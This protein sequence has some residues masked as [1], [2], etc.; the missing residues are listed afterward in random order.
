M[1]IQAKPRR[2]C[3]RLQFK[4]VQQNVWYL[5]N[6]PDVTFIC[7]ANAMMLRAILV[8]RRLA[9]KYNNV[10]VGIDL[11]D[12]YF[13]PGALIVGSCASEDLSWSIVDVVD[14]IPAR[15]PQTIKRV[16]QAFSRAA[17][18]DGIVI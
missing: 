6:S 8:A 2:C 12:D 16:C 4:A 18:C 10:I 11:F 7:S 17:S 9:G 13:V 3:H 1:R 15:S 5:M 14:F